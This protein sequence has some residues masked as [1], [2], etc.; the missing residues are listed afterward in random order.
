M[1]F[2]LFIKIYFQISLAAV[3][4]LL[5]IQPTGWNIL[6][7]LDFPFALPNEAEWLTQAIKPFKKRAKRHI[8][9]TLEVGL[10]QYVKK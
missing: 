4:A 9:S 1:D 3:K 7:E 8:Y 2:L 10:S 6:A 5:R